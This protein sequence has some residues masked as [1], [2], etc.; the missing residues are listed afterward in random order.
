M[1]DREENKLSMYLATEKLMFDNNIIW[2][3]I[4]AIVSAMG[5]LKNGIKFIQKQRQIEELA[6]TGTTK[7][8]AAAKKAAI[9]KALPIAGAL[10]AYAAVTNDNTL[11]DQ[12]NYGWNDLN[13]SR[14]T[15]CH[16]R[17]VLIQSKA[18][19]HAAALLD[20]GVSGTD[21]TDLLNLN[22]AFLA[23]IQ[24]PQVAKGAGVAARKER[25]KKMK[26][27]DALLKERL[28]KLMVMYKTNNPEFYGRYQNA[29]IIIDLGR[30]GTTPSEPTPTPP[31]P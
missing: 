19:D 23:G 15:V 18:D 27:M 31:T 16:D 2:S 24:S 11:K 3:A 8:K 12:V 14:D 1:T 4:V 22:A 21:I 26:E 7:D 20:Y 9:E 10:T 5:D 17:L 25:K 30:R 28:D 6:T 29:R 13:A